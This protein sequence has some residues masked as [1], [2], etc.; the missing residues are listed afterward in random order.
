M[1]FPELVLKADRIYLTPLTRK[2]TDAQM[3][4]LKWTPVHS[5][6]S[7]PSFVVKPYVRE[8]LNVGTK[9]IDVESLEVLYPHLEPIPLKKYSY[10]N[11]EMILGQDVFH[12][13]RPLEY[14]ETNRENTPI[15]VRLPLGWVLSSPLRSTSGRHAS[16]LLVTQSE[17]F[18]VSRP[19]PSLV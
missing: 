4:E 5:G 11:V 10:G 8:E 6:G 17:T 16:K 18:K 12:C 2:T 14:F 15:A 1:I 7:C 9:I 13:I 19:N 3:V